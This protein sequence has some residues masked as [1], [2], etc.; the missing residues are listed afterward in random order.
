MKQIY[1]TPTKQ[2]AKAALKDFADKWEDKYSYAVKRCYDNWK[3]LTV[4][5]EFP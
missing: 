1:N 4:F 2:A 3:D 5:F